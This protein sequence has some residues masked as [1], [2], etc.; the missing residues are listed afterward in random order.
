[1]L[2]PGDREGVR[3]PCSRLETRLDRGEDD[4]CGVDGVETGVVGREVE[5]AETREGCGKLR[6]AG[7][8]EGADAGDSTRGGTGSGSGVGDARFVTL[9]ML[10]LEESEEE[11]E[12][13]L[14]NGLFVTYSA[15]AKRWMPLLWR[16]RSIGVADAGRAF[17]VP[18][19]LPLN[20]GFFFL[21]KLIFLSPLTRRE[22]G[23]RLRGE[24]RRGAD[25]EAASGGEPALKGEFDTRLW[26]RTWAKELDVRRTGPV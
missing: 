20:N 19:E 2:L 21:S 16:V 5:S 13:L 15:S 17:S 3:G 1:M 25:G 23:M 4:D 7:G 14:R 22:V 12:V 10:P 6:R 9:S 26:L 11:T 8:V 18:G 24:G